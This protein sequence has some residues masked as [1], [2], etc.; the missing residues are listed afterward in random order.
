MRHRPSESPLREAWMLG[1]MPQ[2]YY[3]Y[4]GGINW[5]HVALQLLKLMIRR[6]S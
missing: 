1:L 3:N 6:T 2:S 4:E 5:L